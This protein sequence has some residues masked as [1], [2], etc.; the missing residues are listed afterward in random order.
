MKLDYFDLCEGDV[1]VN[2]GA[3]QGKATLFFAPKVGETGK[4]V[5][6]EPMTRNYHA[7][8]DAVLQSGYSNIT[9][10]NAAI[11]EKTG[12]GVLYVGSSSVNYSTTRN[13]GLGAHPTRIISWDD[14]IKAMNLSH[15]T[16][17]KVDVE[18]AELQWLT[19]MTTLFPTHIIM[20]EHSRFG[21]DIKTLFNALK[22]KGYSYVKEG[23]HIYAT[24]RR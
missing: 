10:I 17:A 4:V 14:L 21:Y 1:V 24:R 16:L 23:L 22:E 7:L 3:H 5:S 12:L 8:Q 20:E 11:G 2:L 15:I 19:G 6:M 13:Q 18:G 9:L